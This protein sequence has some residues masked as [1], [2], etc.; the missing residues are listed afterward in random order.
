MLFSRKH[1]KF[2]LVLMV[3]A[4][5][6]VSI[7]CASDVNSTDTAATSDI[8]ESVELNDNLDESDALGGI[9][10]KPTPTL[11][12]NSSKVTTGD[13]IVISLDSNNVPLAEKDLTATINKEDHALFTDENGI[14]KLKLDLPANKYVLNVKFK[15]DESY[16]AVTKTFDIT[17]YKMN[18][19]LSFAKTGLKN[20][21]TFYIYLK[22]IHG[23]P[24]EK[25]PIEFTL[26]GKKYICNTSSEGRA[27]FKI[28][29]APGSY[30]LSID[31]AGN[32]YYVKSSATA[33]IT[34]K[35]TTPK[36]TVAKKTFKKSVKTKKYTV[37]LKDSKG[38]AINKAKLTL[39]V[40]GKTYKATTNKKGKA[41]FK[42]TK[43][44]KKG[45][46]T[47]IVKFAKNAYYNEVSKKVKISVK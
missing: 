43:L 28:T 36:L 45:K 6:S 46:F 20:G 32:S 23:N 1:V 8:S 40:K 17:V 18:T 19:S 9:D 39:K 30:D 38:K 2:T 13:E 41:T 24:V 10:E 37:T 34:V 14:A 16:A 5:F 27:G 25:V 7:V 35:K 26:N 44:N 4:V 12:I 33:K 11:N 22:D 15:G 29:L 47:A 3:F 31:F 42:I 21:E